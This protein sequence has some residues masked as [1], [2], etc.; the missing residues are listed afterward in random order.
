MIQIIKFFL[1]FYLKKVSLTHNCQPPRRSGRAAQMQTIFIALLFFPSFLGALSMVAYTVWSLTPSEQ[2]GPFRGLNRTFAAVSVW[3]EGERAIPGSQWFVWIYENVIRSEVFYFLVTLIILVFIYIIWQ[4]TQ[5]RKL[6]IVLL[7]QQIVNEEK[8]K[9]FLLEKLQLLQKSNHNKPKPKKA[10][11]RQENPSLGGQ[12]SS[13]AMLQ[14]LLARQQLEAEDKDRFYNS[15][16]PSEVSVSTT[17]SAMVQAV[18][19]RN[20]AE[21]QETGHRGRMMPLPAGDSSSGALMLT[22]QARRKAEEEDGAR[23]CGA[24]GPTQKPPHSTSDAVIQVMQARQRAEEADGDP[25][26]APFSSQDPPGSFG[27]SAVAQV[28][29]ARQEATAEEEEEQSFFRMPA[30]PEDPAPPGSSALI[31]AMLARQQA[32]NEYDDGY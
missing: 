22:M 30:H 11:R 20:W 23:D 8:D 13:N 5:G 16:V 15:N 32:Q 21:E 2:C 28:M 26:W 3:I 10:K 31:Q 7:K 6:L 12:S 14:A 24:S 17:S 4:I 29:R 27:S 1:L 25:F 9:T 18:L 19:T